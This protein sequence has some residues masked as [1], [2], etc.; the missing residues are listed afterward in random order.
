Q[1]IEA[2]RVMGVD[3]FSDRGLIIKIWI[4]T[5]PAKQWMIAREFRLRLKL[6]FDQAGI[7]ISVLQQNIAV[8]DRS[9]YFL[10][11]QKT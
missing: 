4:K 3:D 7:S 2:P 8:R 1:I 11:N 10:D 5:Q 6:A 9:K